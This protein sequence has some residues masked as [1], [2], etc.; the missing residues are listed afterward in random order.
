MNKLEISITD[1]ML[2]ALNATAK[3]R[4]VSKEALVSLLISQSLTQEDDEDTEAKDDD[5]IQ[6]L[7]GLA[8]PNFDL[9]PDINPF[10]ETGKSENN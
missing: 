7:S 8:S 9:L 1:E 3:K 10:K 6:A 4:G 2:E 5:S